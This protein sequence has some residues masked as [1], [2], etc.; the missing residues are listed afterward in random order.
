MPVDVL[1][2]SHSMFSFPTVIKLY[3]CNDYLNLS[4]II[5]EALMQSRLTCTFTCKLLDLSIR[6]GL[7]CQVEV[8]LVMEKLEGRR[9]QASCSSKYP[10]Y[11]ERIECNTELYGSAT[12]VWKPES[13]IYIGSGSQGHQTREYLLEWKE[14]V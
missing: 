4:K 14:R 3:H 11:R 9:Y 6:E 10:V 2:A 1:D 8:G 7:T 13:K 5:Q 12:I